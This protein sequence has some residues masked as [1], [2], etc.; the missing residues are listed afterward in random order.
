MTWENRYFVRDFDSS[1]LVSDSDIDT[2]CNIVNYIPSQVL[3]NDHYWLLLN[4]KTSRHRLIIEW[5]VENIY[6]DPE[7]EDIVE[8]FGQLLDCHYV[9]S[10]MLRRDPNFSGSREEEYK[11]QRGNVLFHSGAIVAKAV[12]L[13]LDTCVIACTEGTRFKDYV[14]L[15]SQYHDMILSF[16]KPDL[17]ETDLKY[18][19]EFFPSISIGIGYGIKHTED[20]LIEKHGYTWKG[21]KDNHKIP[22]MIKY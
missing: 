14:E 5:L 16:F 1:K 13:E 9:L 8:H 17:K 20:V 2:L 4:N 6:Y 12:E 15:Q 10:S 18:D 21:Y 19:Y 7:H 11:F 3:N 22:N